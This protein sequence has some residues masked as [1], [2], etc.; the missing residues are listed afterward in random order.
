[1]KI[2][3][4]DPPPLRNHHYL[5]LCDSNEPVKYCAKRKS[6]TSEHSCHAKNVDLAIS[7]TAWSLSAKVPT[8][9]HFSVTSKWVTI[10]KND[11][12][13]FTFIKQNSLRSATKIIRVKQPKTTPHLMSGC[14]Q[15]GLISCPV[16]VFRGLNQLDSPNASH[17]IRPASHR[18]RLFYWVFMT[19]WS[20]QCW[21]WLMNAE[22]CSRSYQME[23]WT[24]EKTPLLPL[25]T[26][27]FLTF[28][29]NGFLSG[30][31]IERNILTL[32]GPSTR[33]LT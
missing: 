25:L 5:K 26:N 9:S 32:I 29:F 3:V 22:L 6:K 17:I 18:C 13:L 31:L 12:L 20:K 30:N 11:F 10:W 14:R 27:V 28:W 19:Q 24:G 4:K 16:S 15:L 23:S 8:N 21:S 2:T 33:S 1:M 7:H